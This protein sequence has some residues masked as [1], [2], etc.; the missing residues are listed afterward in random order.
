MSYLSP[1]GGPPETDVTV[2][3]IDTLGSRS[4][5]VAF[6]LRFGERNAPAVGNTTPGDGRAPAW[7]GY[8]QSGRKKRFGNLVLDRL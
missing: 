8:G 6:R 3:K 2:W 5:Q 7:R 4:C 1:S